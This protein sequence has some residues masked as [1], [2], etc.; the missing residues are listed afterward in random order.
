MSSSAQ[1]NTREASGWT[2]PTVEEL[3]Q[4]LP[5]YEIESML[6]HGG[7]GAVYRGRQA[8]LQRPVAIKV[9]PETLV[10]E[11]DELQYVERFKLEARS[12][13]NMDHP[14]IISVHD[15]GQTAAG[16]LYFVM[17]FIDGMD[18]EQYIAASGGQVDPDHAVAIV[19]HVLDALDYAHSKGILHR[20]IKPANVLINGE[21]RVKIADFGLA[22]EFGG[23]AAEMAGLT[24][25]NMTMGTPDYIA[26]EALEMEVTPDHRADLYAVGVMLYRMLTG[27]LPRGMFKLPSEQNAD[28]DHRFD[29]IISTAMEND[30]AVRFQSATEFRSR[31]DELQSA[32]I[33]RMEA[34]QDSKAVTPAVSGN[35]VRAA[36]PEAVSE[37]E[38]GGVRD[39]GSKPATNSLLWV[40]VAVA[41][42]AVIGVI[43]V[44]RGGL[45][46]HEPVTTSDLTE[47]GLTKPPIAAA[48]L[49]ETPSTVAPEPGPVIPDSNPKSTGPTMPE[50]PQ[51]PVVPQA[52]LEMESVPD[53]LL[54]AENVPSEAP[55]NHPVPVS[56]TVESP[57]PAREPDAPLGAVAEE[58]ET[59]E[60]SD[61]A[62]PDDPD[63]LSR[64]S[65][66]RDYRKKTLGA[67][68]VS[69][70]NRLSELNKSAIS[71]GNL[72]AVNQ[73]NSM[74]ENLDAYTEHLTPLFSRKEIDTL[75]MPDPLS[76]LSET[77][78]P[79][80]QT[81][82][83][84]LV[85]IEIDAAGKLD[86]TLQLVEKTITQTGN[87]ELA[88]A[89]RDFRLQTIE[90]LVPEAI[91][92]AAEEPIVSLGDQGATS[93]GWTTLINGKDF[94]GWTGPE[95]SKWR[96]E[97]G[98]FFTTNSKS[99]IFQFPHTEFEMDG[100]I[101][102]NEKGN[103]GIR[104]LDETPGTF[105]FALVGSE[106]LYWGDVYTG[107]IF[108]LNPGSP[109]KTATPESS[110][111]K[112][113]TW[114]PFRIEVKD[115]RISTWIDGEPGV[116]FEL[117]G[118]HTGQTILLQ[119]GRDEASIVGYR[120]I[121]IRTL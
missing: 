90:R 43:Y 27:K 22:K 109:L 91:Q 69:Y 44:V 17:E 66:Y 113:N 62:M 71:S 18:I 4:Y 76:G 95:L 120:N 119:G 75:P 89:I 40:S 83:S 49:P 12:M 51:D 99:I 35:V 25:T 98:A 106:K 85:D 110:L 82:R 14:A 96:V 80:D 39:A 5:Q 93:E 53:E 47:A 21:G 50:T 45:S 61:P 114:T 121:R 32:P 112:D 42:C 28:I 9:L 73:T 56:P 7:M 116:E 15:F 97:E 67:L 63:F 81:F 68:V 23:E 111:I 79:L 20:D 55:G 101:L 108:Y 33:T 38:S 103:G 31:L 41:A 6:G 59:I 115:G 2:P 88:L 16:H 60:V 57:P 102:T 24:M 37:S 77:L 105:E 74:M 58:T 54:A 10:A 78:A 26:P 8:A 104:F 65:S 86:Q 34:H 117:E 52:P 48:N 11:D 1:G 100:E 92:N 70:R 64:L 3:Q 36:Q 84:T 72:D 46:E 118:E 94:T 13:A 30:P 107:G 29:D 87:L 19:S